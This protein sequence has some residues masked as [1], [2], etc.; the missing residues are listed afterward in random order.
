[1]TTSTTRGGIGFSG[2]LAIALLNGCGAATPI[3]SSASSARAP[4]QLD[5]RQPI[6]VQGNVE[7]RVKFRR[8]VKVKPA[9]VAPNYF[10]LSTQSLK[11]LTDGIGP[12]VVNLT[13]SSPN[14]SPDSLADGAYICT[15]RTTVPA[16]K[17][18]FTVTTYVLPGAAGNVMSTNSTAAID[19]KPIGT[20][21]V[22]LTLEGAV[23]SVILSLAIP[24]PP[25]GVAADIGLTAILEDADQNLI[26]GPAVYEYPVT[27]TTTD[28]QNGP[29]SKAR[30]NSPLD[31]GITVKYSG[32]NVAQI[33]YSATA[34]DLPA[35]NVIAVVL[36]PRSVARLLYVSNEV[37]PYVSVFD[38]E[39]PTT[40]P[41]TIGVDN[42]EG[43]AVDAAGKL[44]VANTREDCSGSIH[45]ILIFDTTRGNAELPEIAVSG[46]GL[47]LGLALDGSGKLYATNNGDSTIRIFDTAHG[48]AALPAITSGELKQ[49]V[50][51]AIDAAGKLYVANGDGRT[52]VFDTRNGNTPIISIPASDAL[53]EA[54]GVAAGDGKLYVPDGDVDSVSVYDTANGDAA[55]PAILGGGMNDPGGAVVDANGRLYVANVFGG[56]VSVFDTT[57]GNAVLP[58]IS[59][60]LNNPV[61]VALGTRRPTK[62]A[63]TS[64]VQHPPQYCGEAAATRSD[65]LRAAS[66]RRRVPLE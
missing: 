4:T 22:S 53:Y 17:H 28:S 7:L 34:N 49:P 36:A 38:L 55:L 9:I 29:L 65:G 1:M 56:S 37:T 51:L 39:N 44:Y 14:C 27:L 12:V 3:V 35:A 60:G 43:V 63:G 16:G 62:P 25:V 57:R 26:V 11:I 8:K 10:S 45:S 19:V 6:H 40:P 59:G 32:A 64:N 52:L 50:G 48:N 21:T 58:A 24:N 31:T 2:A 20:T 42:P 47:L 46:T 13:P 23:R 15:A 30:L 54:W 33:V 18:A 66:S 61:F 41:T 5:H